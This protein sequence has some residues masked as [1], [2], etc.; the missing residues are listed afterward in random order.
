MAQAA[1]V[2]HSHAGGAYRRRCLRCASGSAGSDHI[3]GMRDWA[4][5]CEYREN[6]ICLSDGQTLSGPG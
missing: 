6:H 1:A 2:V 3:A 4:G 5:C